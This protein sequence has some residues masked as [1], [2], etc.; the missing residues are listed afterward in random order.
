[1]EFYH[2]TTL[3]SARGIIENGFRPRG[4]AVWFTN[5]QGYAK[6]RAEH[7]ARRR[8]GDPIVIKTE[9]D[10]EALQTHLGPGKVQI[11]GGII[12][13][14]AHLSI[15]LL[16]SNFFE[17]LACPAALAQWINR[18]LGLY[19]HNGVSQNH[20]GVVRLAHWMSN[21][22]QSGTGQ[23]IERHEFFSKGSQWLPT[24]FDKI[25]FSPEALPIH[26]LENNTI[27][28]RVLYSETAE[29]TISPEKVDARYNRAI[30]DIADQN[31]KKRVRGLQ[32]L[33]KIGV[34]D[35]F[36]WCVLQ[37][38]DESVDVVCNA[39]RIMQRCDAGYTAPILEHAESQEKRIRASAL[40]ALATHA[41]DDGERWFERGLKDSEACV[42][43]E[44]ARLLPT[45][46]R[47][48]HRDIFDLA[49]HDPNPAVKRSAKKRH[50]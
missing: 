33:E 30:A 15:Q 34:A 11:R 8:N 32:L 22:M 35:L 48:E 10:A 14:N 16:R 42:R 29:K 18:Q 21:R 4:G 24:F 49:R 44:V 2:G 31:P 46:N 28:V 13:V 9:L 23:R 1:M 39:L 6:N 19:S 43:M 7:K 50:S 37:L 26:H 12:A 17:L 38:E 45:L 5:Q 47:T 41:A 40:A 36:D 25:P 3:R 27:A 20:W